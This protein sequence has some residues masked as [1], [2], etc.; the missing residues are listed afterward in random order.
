MSPTSASSPPKTLRAGPPGRCPPRCSA[1]GSSMLVLTQ[2]TPTGRPRTCAMPSSS[3]VRR[4]SAFSRRNGWFSGKPRM[5]MPSRTST[6]RQF[7]TSGLLSGLR[8]IQATISGQLVQDVLEEVAGAG[9]WRGARGGRRARRRRRRRG[10]AHGR[11]AA[12]VGRDGVG[13]T[14][15][16][17]DGR[18][19]GRRDDG[20]LRPSGWPP[21]A[22]RGSTRRAAEP[23]AGR[24]GRARSTRSASSSCQR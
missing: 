5:R 20:R 13:G 21:R 6:G 23:G 9:R 19:T 10:A 8:P 15:G 1:T 16:R 22:R 4:C 18:G 17:G 12:G 2:R 11:R 3:A 24:A 7:A 14:A